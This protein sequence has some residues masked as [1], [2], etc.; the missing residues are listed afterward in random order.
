M[1]LKAGQADV[2]LAGG[3]KSAISPGFIQA[4]AAMRA[5]S[6]RNDDPAAA[7]RPFDQDRD[8][9]ELRDLYYNFPN[10]R[11]LVRILQVGTARTC[12]VLRLVAADAR[13]GSYTL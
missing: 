8:G 3:T 2:V 4:Y 6:L 12:S 1:L 7:S 9:P 13:A 11:S 10:S 5:L